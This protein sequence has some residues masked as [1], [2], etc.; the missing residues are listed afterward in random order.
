MTRLLAL[1]ALPAVLLPACVL[2]KV[3][4]GQSATVE[5]SYTGVQAFSL[6]TFL[7]TTVTVTPG[8]ITTSQ[9]IR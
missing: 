5:S 8:G 7:D 4:D 9:D 1:T 2:A 3:G 6:T